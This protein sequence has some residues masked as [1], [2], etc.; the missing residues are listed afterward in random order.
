METSIVPGTEVKRLDTE[1]GTDYCSLIEYAGRTCFDT[2]EKSDPKTQDEFI[3][4]L[5]RKGHHSVIEHSFVAFEVAFDHP[6]DTI[7]FLSDIVNV[8]GLP[9]SV[10]PN[11]DPMDLRFIVSGNFRQYRDVYVQHTNPSKIIDHMIL[12]L[13]GLY[14]PVFYDLHPFIPVEALSYN[15]KGPFFRPDSDWDEKSRRRHNWASFFIVGS[16]VMSHQFVRHRRISPSQR[17]QRFVAEDKQ[18]YITPLSINKADDIRI[19]SFYSTAINAAWNAYENITRRKVKRE[20]ARYILPN[21]CKTQMVMS[22][23]IWGWK[24]F[25][26]LRTDSHAQ[27]EIRKIAFV[28][29]EELDNLL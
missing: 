18:S 22:G 7:D 5:I 15:I 2:R 14:E 3:K 10:T 1:F 17:S 4:R 26:D 19:T 6:E 23:P 24:H 27:E 13:K 16:R 29:Q 8:E 20:D 28:I 25:V 12:S 11:N 9:L 21:A